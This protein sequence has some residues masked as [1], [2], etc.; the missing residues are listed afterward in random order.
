MLGKSRVTPTK[1]VTIPRLELTACSVS[2]KLG[3]M[4][5]EEIKIPGLQDHYLTDSTIALG[6]IYNETRRFRVFV[7]NRAQT[8]RS[9]TSKEQWRHVESG[10]NPADHASR[11]IS[12]NDENAVNQWINGPEFLWKEMSTPNYPDLSAALKD[13]DPEIRG[14]VLSVHITKLP[15][16]DTYLLTKLEEQFSGWKRILRV[17]AIMIKFAKQARKLKPDSAAAARD[18]SDG[19][20]GSSGGG[21]GHVENLLDDD[22]EGV[23]S[24]LLKTKDAVLSVSDLMEAQTSVIRMIQQKYF[25]ASVKDDKLSRLDP[26]ICNKQG[27]LKVGGRV[28]RADFTDNAKHPVILPRDS[29]ISRRVIEYYHSKVSHSGRTTTLNAVR[30]YGFWV[31][32]A[33]G[34]VR[35]IINKCITCRALRGKLGEQ[36]MSDLP[37]ARFSEE[38]PFTYTG[39]D[40]FGP[41]YTKDGRK[42]Q[43]RFVTLFTCMSSRAVHLESMVNMNTDSFIQALRRFLARR[44]VVREIVSDNGKNFVGPKMNGARLSI[45]WIMQR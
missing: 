22:G 5:K 18:G 14:Q 24:P 9:Y 31:V 20:G 44:G 39:M 30:Q 33:N 17:V 13:D 36:K 34:I 45:S 21:S 3:A 8:I 32:G 42:Q 6:Y 29:I 11:G 19:G 27:I 12:V 38:G 7:A 16:D 43:K 2:V 37:K 25:P 35:S 15:T 23:P 41:F 40:M 28:K 26:F 4:I 10:L 1:P